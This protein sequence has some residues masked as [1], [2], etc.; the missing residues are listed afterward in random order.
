[1]VEVS[2]EPL[3]GEKEKERIVNDPTTLFEIVRESPRA[4]RLK[5]MILQK[6]EKF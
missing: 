6:N 4:K 3:F 2:E 1:M 5:L